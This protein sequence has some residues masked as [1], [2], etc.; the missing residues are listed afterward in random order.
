MAM[1]RE[2]TPDREHVLMRWELLE[3]HPALLPQMFSRFAEFEQVLARALAVHTGGQPDDDYPRLMAA[4][5]CTSIRVSVQRWTASHGDHP[6]EYH[7]N[8]IFGLLRAELPAGTASC[9]GI[10]HNS[11]DRNGADRDRAAL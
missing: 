2:T 9:D 10:G 6:L 4:V 7:V 3:R 8:E 1:A 11:A 5:A